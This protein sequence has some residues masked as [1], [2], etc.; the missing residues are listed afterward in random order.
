MLPS[1]YDMIRRTPRGYSLPRTVI[2]FNKYYSK[3]VC[4]R[5]ASAHNTV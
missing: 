5:H 1:L 4:N 3:M 2:S